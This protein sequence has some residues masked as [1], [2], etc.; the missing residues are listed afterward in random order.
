MT[1]IGQPGILSQSKYNEVTNKMGV[2]SKKKANFLLGEEKVSLTSNN[3]L[4]KQAYLYY[5]IDIK[6][7][8]NSLWYTYLCTLVGFIWAHA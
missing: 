4:I 5:L 6:H 1:K 2:V 7:S 3:S 8:N